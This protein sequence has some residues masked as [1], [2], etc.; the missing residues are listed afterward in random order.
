[1]LNIH[2]SAPKKYIKTLDFIEHKKIIKSIGKIKKDTE[3]SIKILSKKNEAEMKKS[4]DISRSLAKQI[5]S[6]RISPKKS[7]IA[8][9]SP[10]SKKILD[11]FELELEL[12][13]LEKNLDGKRKPRKSRKSRKTRKSKKLRKY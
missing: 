13:E 5:S 6:K 1:M 9:L 2:E 11:D 3:K 12:E 10:T 4:A 8:E 7:T